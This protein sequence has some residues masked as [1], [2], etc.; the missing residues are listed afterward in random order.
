MALKTISSVLVKPGVSYG[1]DEFSQ[2]PT[3]IPFRYKELLRYE[4]ILWV[5]QLDEAIAKNAGIEDLT[6][7][8][9]KGAQKALV[10]F[11]EIKPED[12]TK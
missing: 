12:L 11:F 9:A 5:K 2:S 3:F 1:F 7:Q 8:E 10:K 4:A 6:P